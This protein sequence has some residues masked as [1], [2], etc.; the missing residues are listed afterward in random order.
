ME[1]AVRVGGGSSENELKYLQ[2]LLGPNKEFIDAFFKVGSFWGNGL[3]LSGYRAILKGDTLP[4]LIYIDIHHCRDPK[5]PV[6][7]NYKTEY[8]ELKTD[9]SKDHSYEVPKRFDPK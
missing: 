3:T 2:M 7:F 8:R 6:G 5:A 4:K 9:E 1:N